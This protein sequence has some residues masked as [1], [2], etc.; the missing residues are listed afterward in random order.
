ML[1]HKNK[2]YVYYTWTAPLCKKITHSYSGV[3]TSRTKCFRICTRSSS[4]V[5]ILLSAVFIFCVAWLSS[6]SRDLWLVVCQIRN[7]DAEGEERL[8]LQ[9]YV[10]CYVCERTDSCM[11]TRTKWPSVCMILIDETC[12][13][14]CHKSGGTLTV[15]SNLLDNRPSSEPAV[16]TS[17][18]VCVCACV[19]VTE[20]ERERGR[21]RVL[22][23]YGW[24]GEGKIVM[25]KHI[26]EHIVSSGGVD[27][28]VHQFF[29]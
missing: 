18:C 5:L 29:W 6:L 27:S 4:S 9:R 16:S 14:V 20:S 22:V 19:C 8:H 28:D 11:V 7:R 3:N 17:W 26:P 1:S 12:I 15:F 23:D 21:G 10:I 13:S 25:K 2:T 24:D